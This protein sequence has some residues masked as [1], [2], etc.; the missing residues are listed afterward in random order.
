MILDNLKT[1]G[2]QQA[3]REDKISFAS[4][5]PWPGELVWAE[6]RYTEGEE[7]SGTEKSAAIFIGPEFGTVSRPTSSP[8]PARPQ[9][10]ASTS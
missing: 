9:R 6:G 3:H 10:P 2:V 8:L 7:E 4:I 5:S 1:A